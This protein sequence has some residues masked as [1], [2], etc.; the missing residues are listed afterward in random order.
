MCGA[1]GGTCDGGFAGLG[2]CINSV[3]NVTS[4]GTLIGNVGGVGDDGKLYVQSAG[5][6]NGGGS[7]KAR[8]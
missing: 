8:K 2:G 7:K 4:P 5:G 1:S 6:F 3:I